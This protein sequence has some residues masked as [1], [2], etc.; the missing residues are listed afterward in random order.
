MVKI[1]VFG[2]SIAWGAF[3]TER[4][5]WVERLKTYYFQNRES[6][7]Y[8]VYNLAISSNDTKGVLFEL[9]DQIKIIEKIEPDDYVFLFSIGS[10]DCRYLNSKEN[11]FVPI[12]EFENNLKKIIEISK[13]YSSKIIFTGCMKMDETKTMPFTGAVTEKEFYEN[14][15]LKEYND[16]IEKICKDEEVKFIPLWD[17]SSKEDLHDGVHPNSEGHRKIF[18]RVK[19]ELNKGLE[20]N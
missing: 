12:K 19:E 15:D 1:L 6:N 13:K 7:H 16:L 11:K 8:S 20:I 4:G 14:D 10:N 5:G 17:L 9:E 3:D 2:D 18:E